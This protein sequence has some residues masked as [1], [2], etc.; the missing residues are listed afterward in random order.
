MDE[1]F[2]E[3][4]VQ[5]PVCSNSFKQ[6]KIRHN[7]LH[8][9]KSDTDM[10]R[11][12]DGVNPYY[13]EVNVCPQCGFSF[14]DRFNTELSNA[15]KS[16]FLKT[17]TMHWKKQN[18]CGERNLTQ[19][20][21]TLKMALL[22][23]QSIKMKDSVMAGICLR[24]CWLYREKGNSDEEKRFMKVSVDFYK[25]AYEVGGMYGEEDTKPEVIV[26]LLGE[27]NF[28]LGNSKDAAQWFNIAISQYSHD[29]SVKRQFADMIRDRWME[30]KE[31]I[32]IE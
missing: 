13:Y 31:Q 18:F 30:I 27:L 11:Y 5:C 2:Y 14:T 17:I 26:Y 20:I 8:L 29:P 22:C 9:I 24:L 23:G 21:E 25:K 19:A 4:T 15:D 10:C 16:N 7:K 3:K 28:R 12:Y 32:K 6:T 1:T